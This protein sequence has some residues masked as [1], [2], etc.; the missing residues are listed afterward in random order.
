MENK[1]NK[2]MT[3]SKNTCLICGSVFH[4]AFELD[5]EDAKRAIDY[6]NSID[7]QFIEYV[8]STRQVPQ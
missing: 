8:K 6:S 2:K 7:A 4:F 5:R 3:K 1:E